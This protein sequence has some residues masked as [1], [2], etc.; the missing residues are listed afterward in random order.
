MTCTRRIICARI[1]IRESMPA[2]IDGT[3]RSPRFRPYLNGI[4]ATVTYVGRALEDDIVLSDIMR[5]SMRRM[6]ARVDRHE[7]EGLVTAVREHVDA[8]AVDPTFRLATLRRKP[9]DHGPAEN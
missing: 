1:R 4:E 8:H 3:E 6:K 9:H 2:G 5:D 7:V